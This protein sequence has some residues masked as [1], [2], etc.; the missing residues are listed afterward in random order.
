MGSI[1]SIF[2]K[3]IIVLE[4]MCNTVFSQIINR[5]KTWTSE[6]NKFSYFQFRDF[7][8][9]GI[10]HVAVKRFS[11]CH[12]CHLVQKSVLLTVGKTWTSEYNKFCYTYLRNFNH[13]RILHVAVNSSVSN[14]SVILYKYSSTEQVYCFQ[15]WF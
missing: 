15:S 9:R 12:I 13:R 10:L 2:S 1:P 11:Q 14:I 3:G 4:M 8:Q 5:G 6:Y 7:T